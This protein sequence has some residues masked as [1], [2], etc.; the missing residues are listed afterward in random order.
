MGLGQSQPLAQGTFAKLWPGSIDPT[1]RPDRIRSLGMQTP[2][3]A[4]SAL[5]GAVLAAVEFEPDD[6]FRATVGR[7]A[8]LAEAYQALVEE[9]GDVLPGR[10]TTPLPASELASE[11]RLGEAA[12]LAQAVRTALGWG[13]G[14]I[15]DHLLALAAPHALVFRLPLED[16]HSGFFYNHPTVGFCVVVNSRMNLGRHLFSLATQLCHAFCHSHLR[17]SWFSLPEGEHQRLADRFAAQLLVPDSALVREVGSLGRGVDPSDPVVALHIQRLFG[18][19]YALVAVRL[20]Q[21]GLITEERYHRMGEVSPTAMAPDLG[22]SVNPVDLG[23]G[24]DPPP[25]AAAPRPMLQLVCAAL[26]RGVLSEERA[27][28]VLGVS[29]QAV[30]K[31]RSRPPAEAPEAAVW[32]QMDQLGGW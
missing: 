31:L 21:A 28:K 29:P 20:R 13:E 32:A 1:G 24:S 22:Y 17:D 3:G 18:V 10:G 19:S 12:R 6:L 8:E 15:A 16:P 9:M 5:S 27:G 2:A 26:A 14:P 30:S 25:L 4:R 23:R 11:P 7:F